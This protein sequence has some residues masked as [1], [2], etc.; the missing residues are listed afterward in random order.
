VLIDIGIAFE[1]RAI[2]ETFDNDPDTDTDPDPDPDLDQ[3]CSCCTA[4]A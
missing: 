2:G 1:I 4:K 3:A